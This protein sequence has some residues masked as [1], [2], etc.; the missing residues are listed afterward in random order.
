MRLRGL[1]RNHDK[2]RLTP[3]DLAALRLLGD[4][5]SRIVRVALEPG[6]SSD[7]LARVYA[8][9]RTCADLP[10]A[11]AEG[12]ADKARVFRA[13]QTIEELTRGMPA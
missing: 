4:V 9:A 5:L 12:G 2:S 3:A 11:I 10:D 7:D 13:S 6:G 8:L 1:Q